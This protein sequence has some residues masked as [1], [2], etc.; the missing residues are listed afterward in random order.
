V[1]DAFFLVKL[2]EE[3][4]YDGARHFDARPLRVESEQGI[5]DFAAG[6]MR[7][8]LALKDAAARWAGD[9]EIAAAEAAAKVPEL[10]LDTVGP[11]SPERADELLAEQHDLAAL[12]AREGRNE[13]LD[14]LAVDLIL[15]LR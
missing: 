2:L 10:A 1:K 14:Q 5:W 8:Y 3:S 7:T 11:Y 9:A 15:G 4:G 12:G 13:R 6:C